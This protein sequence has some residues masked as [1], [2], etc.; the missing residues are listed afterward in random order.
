[1]SSQVVRKDVNFKALDITYYIERRNTAQ[2]QKINLF[3]YIHTIHNSNTK[4]YEVGRV[5]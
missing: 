1:M 5:F 3:L 2:W 4:I